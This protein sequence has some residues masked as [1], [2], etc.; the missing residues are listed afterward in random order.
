VT[1]IY[2]VNL[3]LGAASPYNSTATNSTANVIT[4]ATAPLRGLAL[5]LR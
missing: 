5:T 4:G 1:S 2:S 3:G